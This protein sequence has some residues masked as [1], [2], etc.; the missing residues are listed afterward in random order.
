[1]FRLLPLIMIAALATG[2]VSR[3]DEQPQTPPASEDNGAQPDNGAANDVSPVDALRKHIQELAAKPEHSANEVQVQHILISHAGVA[4]TGATRSLEEAESLVADLWLRIKDGADFD[5]LVR[6][7]TND[8]YPGRY[9]MLASG[10][11]NHRELI[12]MRTEMARAFG[13]V[14]WRLEVGE[15]GV[16]GND[17]Q[18]SPFGWHIIKRL[19]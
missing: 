19:R 7:Y 9:T 14:G 15:V 6:E 5:A 17:A 8:S 10:Q 4:R 12:F 1:M 3:D 13:D 18:T 16:A 11:S 2:C